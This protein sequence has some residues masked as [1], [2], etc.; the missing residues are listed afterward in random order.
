[1][2]TASRRGTRPARRA[3]DTRPACGGG[4]DRC[5]VGRMEP[6]KGQDR[7]LRAHSLLRER[8]LR[9]RT[10]IVGGDAYGL[11]PQY[12]ASLPAL[13]ERLGLGDRVTMTGQVADAGPYVERMDVLVNASN[14]EPFGIVLLEAMARGIAVVAVDSGG[15]SEF[16][17]HGETGMLAVPERR[18]HWQTRSSR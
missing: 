3:D 8:G 2:V 14:P 11:S 18:A 7:L 16:I 10:V 1:M 13:I 12:A 5:I 9:L 17:E 6:W 4:S 15:P